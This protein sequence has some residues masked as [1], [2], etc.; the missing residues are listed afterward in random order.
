M[1][2]TSPDSVGQEAPATTP[3]SPF[4]E[5]AALPSQPEVTNLWTLDSVKAF[6]RAVMYFADRH[7]PF[8]DLGA[9]EGRGAEFMEQFR[10]KRDSVAVWA[11]SLAAS[12]PGSARPYRH[13]RWILRQEWRRMTMTCS[14]EYAH[15]LAELATRVLGLAEE[16]EVHRQLKSTVEEPK[17]I[18]AP[19]RATGGT[20]E[21][22]PADPDQS[23]ADA[24]GNGRTTEPD[25]AE[26]YSEDPG[27]AEDDGI[28]AHPVDGGFVGKKADDPSWQKKLKGMP[29]IDFDNVD[30]NVWM[31]SSA[32]QTQTGLKRDYLKG[33][34]RRDRCIIALADA[35]AGIDGDERYFRHKPKTKDVWYLMSSVVQQNLT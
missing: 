25:H 18:A 7:E 8:A 22:H 21:D 9:P 27:G 20:A 11:S 28:A 2:E 6:V 5:L 24:D 35:T 30:R 13:I 17:K 34:R 31:D 3:P 15:K 16:R 10:Q 26:T 32:V 19:E 14:G 33:R 4:D 29:E 12:A 23:T 1:T